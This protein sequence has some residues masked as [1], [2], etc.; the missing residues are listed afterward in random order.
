VDSR[1]SVPRPGRGSLSWAAA[2]D[3]PLSV[4][5]DRRGGTVLLRSPP[6][7]RGKLRA[8]LV[9]QVQNATAAMPVGAVLTRLD[10]A[11]ARPC[12]RPLVSGPDDDLPAVWLHDDARC[13]TD[14]DTR[15]DR[16]G[17]QDVSWPG[18]SDAVT[19][20]PIAIQGHLSVTSDI[21]RYACID[22]KGGSGAAVRN[23][24]GAQAGDDKRFKH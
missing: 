22:R 2:A 9:D 8:L 4:V 23:G 20:V 1:A 12:A 6:I 18:C 3:S 13:R 21:G 24:G 11:P 7:T 5:A 16:R 17:A 10:A 15:R 19:A 14:D